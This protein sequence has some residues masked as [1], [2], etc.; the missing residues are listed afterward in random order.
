M[1]ASIPVRAPE[2]IVAAAERALARVDR[3]PG[4]A[5]LATDA[6]GTLWTG[7]VGHDLFAALL[8]E[9]AIRAEATEAISA[10]ARLHGL[11]ERGDPHDVAARI[12][13][14]APRSPEVERDGYAMMAWAFAGWAVDEVGAFAERV[15]ERE[16]IAERAHHEMKPILAWASDRGVPI[17][18]VSASPHDVVSRAVARLGVDASLVVATT[19]ATA[20]GRVL[21]RLAPPMPYAAGKVEA[22]R[23]A[24]PDARV[25]A[26]FGD[27]AFDV[28]LLGLAE[29]RV[30]V[31]PKASLVRRAAA[32]EGLV[33]VDA[34]VVASGA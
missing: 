18:V 4:A 7:D 15:L 17:V 19:A 23:A 20:A 6:D 30:A 32:V 14:A 11:D 16:C 9:R 13:E 8:R 33:A 22:L 10:L 31:R 27:S 29:V 2:E 3:A 5:V 34:R 24:R 12:V 26:A 21:P 1:S 25:V 28:E